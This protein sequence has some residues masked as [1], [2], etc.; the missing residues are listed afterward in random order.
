MVKKR[1]LDSPGT[2]TS[3][4]PVSDYKSGVSAMIQ[5]ILMNLSLSLVCGNK[6]KQTPLQKLNIGTLLS[7]RRHRRIGGVDL[8][9]VESRVKA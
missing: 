3:L 8:K 2:G 1:P 4:R 5:Y 9:N 7:H 6:R